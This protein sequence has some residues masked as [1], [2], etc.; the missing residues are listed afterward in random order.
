MS[1]HKDKRANNY[2]EVA[3]YLRQCQAFTHRSCSAHWD[4]THTTYT[5][6]SYRTSIAW[7]NVYGET[8]AD[9]SYYSHTTRTHQRHVRMNLPHTAPTEGN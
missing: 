1:I 4:E 2:R 6:M 7:V 9:T 8:Y 3:A 5:V